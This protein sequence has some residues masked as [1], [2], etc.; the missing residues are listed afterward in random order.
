MWEDAG[1][2]RGY[3]CGSGKRPHYRYLQVADQVEDLLQDIS[4]T[5]DLFL[6]FFQ[7]SFQVVLVELLSEGDWV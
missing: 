1:Y 6:Q 5:T 3:R 2:L 4:R 7:L